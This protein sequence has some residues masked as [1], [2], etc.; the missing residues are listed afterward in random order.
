MFHAPLRTY[1]QKLD[2]V[3]EASKHRRPRTVL[4]SNV[5]DIDASGFLEL[6]AVHL[7]S[8][9]PKRQVPD[10]SDFDQRKPKPASSTRQKGKG[11]DVFEVGD[12]QLTDT[13]YNRIPKG[14]G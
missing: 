6:E 2:A 13:G 11:G 7:P 8:K 3:A 4:T 12:E 1:R 5:A 14:C 10:M 9:C